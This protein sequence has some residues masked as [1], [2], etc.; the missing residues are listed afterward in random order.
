[1][2]NSLYKVSG[3]LGLFIYLFIFKNSFPLMLVRW[4]GSSSHS[5]RA[6][7][8]LELTFIPLRLFLSSQHKQID[9]FIRKSTVTI[10]YSLFNV[11]MPSQILISAPDKY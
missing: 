8:H 3:C 6:L 9:F 10:I 2:P 11:W 5:V 1:M 4:T 7:A